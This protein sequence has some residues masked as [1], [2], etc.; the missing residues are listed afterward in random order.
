VLIYMLLLVNKPWLMKRW[1][2]NRLYN[3]VAWFAVMIMI[4]L[5]LALV[6]LT[7]R[8]GQLSAFSGQLSAVSFQLG[9]FGRGVGVGP[10]GG[11]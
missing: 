9:W 7:I 11:G 3:L 1:V 4:G 2:N 5:T 6:A 10:G 8:D